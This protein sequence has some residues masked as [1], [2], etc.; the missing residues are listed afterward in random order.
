MMSIKINALHDIE[1]SISEKIYR[2]NRNGQAYYIK[3]GV[4]HHSFLTW[5]AHNL[6][7]GRDCRIYI[8]DLGDLVHIN[9]D[10]LLPNEKSGLSL[11]ESAN[12]FA[13]RF[14]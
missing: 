13:N 2:C 10:E 7:I 6:S 12:M 3:N 14:K 11:M 4:Y 8:R 5:N 9:E 1:S